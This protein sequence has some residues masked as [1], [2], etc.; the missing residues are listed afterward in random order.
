MIEG[1]IFLHPVFLWGLLAVLIPIAV[2]LFNF[3]RYRK[4]YFS[5]VDRLVALHT[6]S[7]RQNNLRQ[8]LILALRVL[9]IVC[10]VLAFSQPVIGTDDTQNAVK[11]SDNAVSIYLDNTFSMGSASSDGSQLDQACRKVR[12]I[13][14]IY[15]IGSRYQLLTADMD[16]AQMHW[17]NRDEL[18]DAI[19]Q[20]QLTPASP[21]LS[22]VV[23]RQRAFLQQ[24]GASTRHA[25]IISDFQHSVCDFDALTADSLAL[26]TLVPIGG[27]EADN[28]YIDTLR[29]DAPAYFAGGVVEVEA[30]LRNHGG[31][32]AEKVPVRLL[33]NG[34]E[35]A[36]ATVDLAAGATGKATLRF[37]ID[38]AG[39][40][41]GMVEI[42]DYPVIFDDRY[43]F[44]LCTGD[45]IRILETGPERANSHLQRLFGTEADMSYVWQPASR[46]Q[47]SPDHDFI[48]IN[49]ATSLTSGDAQQLAS[50]V[51][52]GGSLLIVAPAGDKKPSPSLN[53]ALAILGAPQLGPWQQ[54]QTKANN[55]DFGH[56][57][58][59]GVFSGRNDEMEM[60]TVQGHY[61]LAGTAARQSVIGLSD[62]GALLTHTPVGSGHLYLFTCPLD[63]QW[64]D[65]VGQALFVPTLY[66]MALYSRPLPPASHTLGADK[67]VALQGHYT[68][69]RQPPE[70]NGPGDLRI[71]PDL[72]RIGNRSMLMLHGELSDA[73]SYHLA[74]E[75]IAFNHPRRES[76]LDFYTAD[77]VKNAVSDLHGFRVANH[78]DKPL[79]GQLTDRDSG[80]QL[81][82]LFIVLALAALAAETVLLAIGRRKNKNP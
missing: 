1:M 22:T 3:R 48:V 26:V 15:G 50:W 33:V 10:L 31:H 43:Y 77:E 30:S 11:T 54:H 56:R 58:F 47:F 23:E 14:D 20:V 29:L 17:L 45:H 6:E 36:I 53:E 82:R 40:C 60:P 64:T 63:A 16:G 52:D 7:R 19:D 72:R 61:A 74:D 28:I 79:E 38:S 42:N 71:I 57:L 5:N 24:S 18:L 34:R 41:D 9:A 35:R 44:T 69:D 8:W 73:G 81:W 27:I 32:D 70:L 21:L 67:A 12:E 37:T 49:S 78:P 51:A 80:H 55:V 75:H 46:F 62:G 68:A 65:L 59:R 39:W 76:Q 13:A 25:Y 4:V 2:H 66:N